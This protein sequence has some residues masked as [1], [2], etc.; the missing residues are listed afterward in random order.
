MLSES[1]F[2]KHHLQNTQYCCESFKYES[3]LKASFTSTAS[4]T[5]R[6]ECMNL[7]IQDE[8]KNTHSSFF[9]F[10]NCMEGSCMPVISSTTLISAWTLNGIYVGL[11]SSA[12]VYVQQASC[13]ILSWYM[14]TAKR[15]ST[16]CA[17]KIVAAD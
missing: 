17:Q 1:S 10:R 15:N 11:H 12:N 9:V 16:Y 3:S 7:V 5:V 2:K 4:H 13:V 6:L 8:C 14:C